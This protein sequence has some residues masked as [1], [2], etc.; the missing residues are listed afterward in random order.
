MF[1][2]VYSIYPDFS[3]NSA[4]HVMECG[5]ENCYSGKVCSPA[6]RDHH[7]LHFVESG[8]G[9]LEINGKNYNISAGQGFYIPTGMLA[10]Y[11]A[12]KENPWSYCWLGFDGTDSLQVLSF[13]NLSTQYPIF[14]FSADSVIRTLTK[15]LLH[16]YSKNGNDFLSISYLYRIL[17]L[18]NPQFSLDHN[19]NT[20]FEK[21]VTYVKDNFQSDI[22]VTKAAEHFSIS[23]SQLFRDFKKYLKMSP[24]QYIKQ[25]RVF[26][27][28]HLLSTT[29]LPISQIAVLSGYPDLCNFSKQFK[30]I[31]YRS[32][33]NYRKYIDAHAG[34]DAHADFVWEADHSPQG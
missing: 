26:Y 32:P 11:I 9:T 29:E 31:Y 28:A 13:R 4:L 30:S 23:T 19:K 34:I 5:Y 15:K 1:R 8:K 20:A 21:L 16:T 17:S 33:A 3:V 18:I 27:A 22:S 7:L 24:Q 2:Y 6:S 14:D 12:D 10:K 25:Y